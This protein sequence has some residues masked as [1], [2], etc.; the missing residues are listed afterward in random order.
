MCSDTQV[1]MSL[2]LSGLCKCFGHPD[3]DMDASVRTWIKK[4]AACKDSCKDIANLLTWTF[5]LEFCRQYYKR[6]KRWPVV[7]V[8]LEAPYKI[9]KNYLNNLWDERATAS[10]CPENFQHIVL[11]K[12][13]DFDY[14][15]DISDLLSD[16]SIIPERA[17]WIHKYDHRTRPTAH[18]TEHSHRD[19]LPHPRV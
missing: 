13:L 5:R 12:N 11:D 17:Q 6:H 3:I 2:E 8:E 7:T 16:K 1:H 19:L 9:R 18:Y 14:H 4:G 10:W 15:V